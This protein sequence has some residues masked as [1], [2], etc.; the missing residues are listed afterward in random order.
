MFM[1]RVCEIETI[2][3]FCR[4]REVISAGGQLEGVASILFCFVHYLLKFLVAIT[5]SLRFLVCTIGISHLRPLL[6]GMSHSAALR[7]IP[8]L[9]LIMRSM[10]L[11]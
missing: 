11:L 8:I 3:K 10:Q 6:Q 4:R 5:F 9:S 2:T 1:C 7:K